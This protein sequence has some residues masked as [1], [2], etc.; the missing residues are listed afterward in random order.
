MT[1]ASH[2]IT[3]QSQT[4]T[5][6]STHK[7]VA[8][9]FWNKHGSLLVEFM[10]RGATINKAACSAILPN[11]RRSLENKQHGLLTSGVLLLHNNDRPNSVIHT[12]NLI[13]FL[14]GKRLTNHYGLRLVC[15]DFHLVL[16]GVS[17]QKALYHR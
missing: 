3:S 9:V 8:T 17:Q 6:N 1:L 13:K 14:D 11:F 12:Q 2:N 16:K 15:N 10:Q 5:D 7:I 4:Q